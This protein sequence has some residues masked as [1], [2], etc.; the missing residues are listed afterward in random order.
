MANFYIWMILWLAIGVF[1]LVTGNDAVFT[2]GLVSSTVHVV[3]LEVVKQINKK[4]IN[5]AYKLFLASRDA[6]LA[7]RELKE[8]GK[9]D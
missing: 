6:R 9:G 5:A 3:G 1:G 8:A 4:E 7:Q 2:V